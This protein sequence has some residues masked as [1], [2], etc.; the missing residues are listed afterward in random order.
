MRERGEEKKKEIQDKILHGKEE[1]E[2]QR[3]SQKEQNTCIICK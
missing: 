1:M 3:R 2:E